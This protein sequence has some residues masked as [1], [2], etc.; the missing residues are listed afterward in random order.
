MLSP[1]SQTRDVNPLRLSVRSIP[2]GASCLE[3]GGVST[4]LTQDKISSM[5]RLLRPGPALGPSEPSSDA[6]PP[7]FFCKREETGSGGS[8]HRRPKPE[9]VV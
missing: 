3:I 1:S 8:R 7:A 6:L 2:T 4:N 9:A 5:S